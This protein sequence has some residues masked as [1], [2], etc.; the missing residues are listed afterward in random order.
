MSKIENALLEREYPYL[1][2]F[3][4]NN[5]LALRLELSQG[6][7]RSALKRA[8]EVFSLL[9]EN[10]PDAVVFNY[11]LFDLSESG[12]AEEE[13]FDRPGEA[14][15]VNAG[16][17]R[18]A[19][20]MAR[21]LLGFQLKYRHTVVRD[22][23]YVLTREDGLVLNNRVICYSDGKGFDN[24]KLLAQCAADR[25][26]PEIGFVSFENECVM[27]VYDDRGCDVIFADREK[28]CEFYPKLK[29]YFLEHD[30]ELME[31]RLKEAGG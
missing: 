25:F 17:V 24:N 4:Y 10:A 12:R 23:P 29:P 2:P 31:K 3:F 13:A 14:E 16:Y 1:P 15:A 26:D 6:S 5:G 20:R 9:F 18:D 30:L 11:R 21:F 7:R 8:R 19:A 28:F 27:C 22:T